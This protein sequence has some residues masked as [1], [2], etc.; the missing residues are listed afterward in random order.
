MALGP[1]LNGKVGLGHPSASDTL[2]CTCLCI[3]QDHSVQVAGGNWGI[4][5]DGEQSGGEGWYGE[6]EVAGNISCHIRAI[7][8]NL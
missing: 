5:R 2:S 8:K 1:G 6:A 7:E 4:E 3:L